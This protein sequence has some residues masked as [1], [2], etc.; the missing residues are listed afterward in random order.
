MGNCNIMCVLEPR[1]IQVKPLRLV[2]SSMES[3]AEPLQTE[4]TTG[5][6][7]S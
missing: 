4:L 1:V 2:G 5:P 7:I 3:G 6:M